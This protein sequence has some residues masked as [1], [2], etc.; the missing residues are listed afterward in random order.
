MS[1]DGSVEP[2]NPT[3]ECAFNGPGARQR[4]EIGWQDSDSSTPSPQTVSSG[5]QA[6]YSFHQGRVLWRVEVDIPD[7]PAR[8]SSALESI[9][10]DLG[11]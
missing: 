1:P 8:A 6:D 10:A 3:G 11:A 2:M 5:G 9:K 4:V 7:D